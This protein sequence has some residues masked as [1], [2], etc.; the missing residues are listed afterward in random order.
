MHVCVFVCMNSCVYYAY[1]CM[2]TC[3]CVRRRLSG[4]QSLR[5]KHRTVVTPSGD[6]IVRIVGLLNSAS[7]HVLNVNCVC[8]TNGTACIECPNIFY[9]KRLIKY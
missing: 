8:G 9:A 5:A 3:A 7:R 4:V 2:S 1:K 6:T